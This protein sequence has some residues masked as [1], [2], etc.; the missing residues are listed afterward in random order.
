MHEVAREG[1]PI[2]I[3]HAAQHSPTIVLSVAG[4][5]AAVLVVPQ[6]SCAWTSQWYASASLAAASV[7]DTLVLGVVAVCVLVSTSAPFLYRL[8]T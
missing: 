4:A 7:N 5:L 2:C 8:T 6:A 1:A 3:T